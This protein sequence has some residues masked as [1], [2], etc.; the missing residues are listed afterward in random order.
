MKKTTLF[1][2]LFLIALTAANLIVKYFG[3]QGLW[4]SSFLLIPFDFICRCIFHETW[5]GKKLIIYLSLLTL[6]AS[7]LTTAINSSAINIAAG[8]VFGFMA[9]QI[10]AGIFYQ[11]QLKRNQSWFMKINISDLIAICCDSLVFQFVA[12]KQFDYAIT[13]GQIA[14]KFAG[15]LMWYF[16]LFKV[17]NIQKDLK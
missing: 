7:F 4:I 1:I 16:I 5:K 13:L 3:A 12:F 6:A 9:A 2:A 11:Y 15:G 8:S 17:I 10:G 14:I